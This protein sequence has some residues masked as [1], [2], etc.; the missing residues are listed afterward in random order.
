[1]YEHI[2]AIAVNEGNYCEQILMLTLEIF[3]FDKREKSNLIKL[4]AEKS[5]SSASNNNKIYTQTLKFLFQIVQ[6]M[7]S[8][9]NSQYYTQ[10]GLDKPGQ[11]FVKPIFEKFI[12]V[13]H[14]EM[15]PGNPTIALIKFAK[16][17]NVSHIK[18]I[19]L[20]FIFLVEN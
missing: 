19:R 9:S 17:L 12:D 18:S 14:E 11:Q 13:L 6:E 7:I 20:L 8:Y 3:F 16:A 2:I 10:V 4:Q 15:T 1:M 5:A